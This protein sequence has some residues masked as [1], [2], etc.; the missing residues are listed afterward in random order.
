MNLQHK[1]LQNMS[2]SAVMLMSSV[3]DT[4]LSTYTSVLKDFTILVQLPGESVLVSEI[5][6][7]MSICAKVLLCS[8]H[9]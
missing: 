3:N 1:K 9:A 7:V 2:A 8:N 5:R 6:K 4:N